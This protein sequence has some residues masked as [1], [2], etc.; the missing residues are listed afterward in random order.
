MAR[1]GGLTAS[2][3]GSRQPG[4]RLCWLDLRRTGAD[5]PAIMEEALHHGID[6]LLVASPGDLAGLP[7]TVTKILLPEPGASHTDLAGA[8]V[9]LLRPDERA[10]AL[11]CT[12]TPVE[13]GRFVR[14]TD[15]KSLDLACAAVRTSP[16][17]LLEFTDPTKIP[18]EIVLAAADRAPGALVT[19]VADA[20]EARVVFGVLERGSEGVLLAPAGIGVAAALRAAGRDNEEQVEL[21]ELRVTG[22]SRVGMGERACVDM[23]ANLGQNEGLLVG[24]YAR[25]QALCVSETHPLPYMPTR[26]FRVNAGALHSYTLAP[27]GRTR[28]LSELRSGS[29]VLAV[30][31][32]GAGRP[33]TVGRVKIES[34]PLLAIDAEGPAGEHVNLIVQDDWHVRVLGPGAAV[35]NVTELGAGDLLLGHLPVRAR[36]VGYPIDEFC[37]EQ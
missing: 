7:P 18:L 2:P 3:A 28:Y 13:L 16:W 33:V 17:T 9:L 30:T 32:D 14:V 12:G 24:S 22:I 4:T 29:Q 10:P 25:G 19:V 27:G 21:A 11:S 5:R 26:P 23:C 8:D 15:A 37:V 34:R 31:A 1:S 20:E 35:R 6:G 36:H